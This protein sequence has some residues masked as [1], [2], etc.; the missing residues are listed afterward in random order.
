MQEPLNVH[1]GFRASTLNSFDIIGRSGQLCIYL[2][3]NLGGA[4]NKA[5]DDLN[6]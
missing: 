3:S 5:P 6:R 2:D 4:L 1:T